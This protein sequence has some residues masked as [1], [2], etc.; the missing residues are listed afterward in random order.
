MIRLLGA[1]LLAASLFMPAPLFAQTS[2]SHESQEISPPTR[3]LPPDARMPDLERVTQG[4]IEQT[5][6]LRSEH[7]R[8]KLKTNDRLMRSAQEFADFMARTDKYGHTAD[9]KQPS[10]RVKEQ[11]YRYS[12]V[13]ENIAWDY[14]SDGFGTQQLAESLMQG[15]E[16]SP[17]HR[18]NL[19][20]RDLTDI[21]VGVAY[22]SHSGR[23]Y[24][25]Q[26]FGRPL[27]M[28]IHFRITN[29]SQKTIRY[30]VDDRT[31]RLPPRYTMTYTTARSPSVS[32]HGGKDSKVIHPGNGAHYVVRRDADGQLEMT[33]QGDK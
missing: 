10:Q 7:G 20:D 17:P 14:D 6:A 32:L 11:G 15:W 22:S 25:V 12:L 18:R 2:E 3:G 13:A 4:I 1:S 31:Y 19:L 27:S 16:H 9:G 23:F 26:D 5:N 29:D 30:T 28:A 8:N 33:K 24:A 21:G